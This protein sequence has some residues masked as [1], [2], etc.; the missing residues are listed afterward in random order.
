[1]SKKMTMDVGFDF[2]KTNMSA[3]ET[4]VYEQQFPEATYLTAIPI[5]GAMPEWTT[6]I[7]Y[8]SLSATG[9]AKFIATGAYDVPMLNLDP[10]TTAIQVRSGGIGFGYSLE[11]LAQSQEFGTP[12][13]SSGA[14][15][16]RRF[17]E[18]HIQKISMLGDA[19]VGFEG[20]VNNTNVPAG[21]ATT[22]DWLTTAT[23]AQILQDINDA[24]SD[25]VEDTL[26]VERP[27][28]LALP[29]AQ[30]NFI[31]HTPR[32]VDSDM[33]I[34]KFV[35]ANSPYITSLAQIVPIVELKG[36]GTLAADRMMVY[37]YAEDKVVLHTPMPFNILD[38]QAKGLGYEVPTMYRVGGVEFRYPLS[39]AYY[40][41]I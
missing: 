18:Q 24:F 2:L 38:P 3:V 21:N 19:D 17:A 8:R 33:T 37:T 40:D 23:P 27:N 22:G 31:M 6:S 5:S 12:I 28:R 11:D 4:K 39:A 9:M 10:K 34:A 26:N 30:W 41:G 16:A 36:A 15:M 1:M 29:L 25:V 35:V 13:D 14:V 7:I 32:S 20:F